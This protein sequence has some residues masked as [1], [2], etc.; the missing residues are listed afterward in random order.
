[1]LGRLS[2]ICLGPTRRERN[3]IIELGGPI[4]ACIPFCGFFH[5][6]SSPDNSSGGLQSEFFFSPHAPDA[7]M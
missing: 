5:F 2:R 3:I 4:G 7:Q 6:V 1:V